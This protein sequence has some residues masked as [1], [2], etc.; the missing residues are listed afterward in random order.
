MQVLGNNVSLQCCCAHAHGLPLP[1]PAHTK[2]P[3]LTRE[4]FVCTPSLVH[5][6]GKIGC[7]CFIIIPF[8]VRPLR[9]KPAWPPVLSSCLNSTI[10]YCFD[11]TAPDNAALCTSIA[12]HYL[13]RFTY[14]VPARLMAAQKKKIY[15]WKKTGRPSAPSVFGPSE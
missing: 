14:V 7:P 2:A 11:Q 3:Y 13:Q 6:C 15:M 10:L 5:V 12:E 9:Y 1:I 4:N 8:I